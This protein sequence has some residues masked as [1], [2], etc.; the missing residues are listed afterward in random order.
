MPIQAL[1]LDATPLITH[2]YQH[3]ANYS[4]TFYTTPTV[5]SE[6]KD[7]NARKNLE[8]WD[9]LGVLVKRHPN[10]S[11]IE[12]VKNFSVLTGDFQVLSAN[13]IHILALTYELQVELN[14]HKNV[15]SIPGQVLDCDQKEVADNKNSN[16]EGS[17]AAK[18]DGFTTTEKPK[19]KRG[20]RGGKKQKAKQEA[21]EQQQEGHTEVLKDEAQ[22]KEAQLEEAQLEE[23]Q[24]EEA[25]LEEAQPE[26]AQLEEAQPEEAQLEEAQL[27]GEYFEDD[28]DG[29]WITPG[30]LAMQMMKD[31][32]EDVSGEQ[33]LNNNTDGDSGNTEDNT[34][35]ALA[36]GDFAVQNVALQINLNLMNFM[37]GFKIT[38]LR[39]YMLRCHACFHM[40]PLNTKNKL[41]NPDFCPSCGGFQTLL[42]CAISIDA[43]T[44]TIVPHLKQNFQWINRGNKYSVASPLSKRNMRKNGNKGFQHNNSKT[45][46]SIPLLRPD[47]K[48][49]EQ[50]LKQKNYVERYNEKLLNNWYGT[51]NGGMGGSADNVISP[52][53]LDGL[54]YHSSKIGRG[55]HVNSNSKRRS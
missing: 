42:R 47:Q 9:N 45:L 38:K 6:I 8:I 49:Y 48:E 33:M 22:P 17:A 46:Q 7:A 29:D 14:G 5:Y 51:E 44:G 25:Q 34:F 50:H 26:E 39:N 1:V 23:A 54:K 52:F 18:E 4:K 30:T 55:R 20:R 40:C 13:D 19:K 36:T 11:S 32:G 35:V 2:G 31:Q 21:R 12:F 27:E 10:Q 24:L 3:Y 28:D 43:E 37:N 41:Q 53:G 15:R 16:K